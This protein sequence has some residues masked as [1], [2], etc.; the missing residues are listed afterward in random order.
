M[1]MLGEEENMSELLDLLERFDCRKLPTKSNIKQSLELVHKE[2]IQ[3]AQYA[4]DSWR[5]VIRISMAG[6][7]AIM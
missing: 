4:V 1:R 6:K 5:Y 3:K 2:L 7:E